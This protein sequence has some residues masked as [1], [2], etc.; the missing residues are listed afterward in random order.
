MAGIAT[1][2]IVEKR[3][4]A[5]EGKRRIDFDRDDFIA[6]IQTW[7]DEYEETITDQLKAMGCSCDWDRQAVHHGRTAGE[8]R[9]RGVFS[10]FSR[11]G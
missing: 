8:G 7:K 2:T 3:V 4:L 1:Q 9:A 11:R 10:S 5:E 6:K